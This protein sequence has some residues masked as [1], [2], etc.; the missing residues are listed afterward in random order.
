MRSDGTQVS[1]QICEP[2]GP[3]ADFRAIQA[4]LNPLDEQ[5]HDPGLLGR[6]QLVPKRIEPLQ[7]LASALEAIRARNATDAEMLNRQLAL[8]YREAAL[9][10]LETREDQTAAGSRA[11]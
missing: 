7:R 2:L 6:K 3:P 1:D 5:L 4:D 8:E 9:S 11:P 10:V